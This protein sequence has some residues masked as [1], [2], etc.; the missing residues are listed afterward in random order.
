[1]ALTGIFPSSKNI[2]VP[3]TDL[4]L[5]RCFNC[6]LIQL[7]EIFDTSV[8]FGKH[9]G[10][11]SSVTNTM[12]QHLIE[13]RNLCISYFKST[14]SLSIL[15]IGSN[16]GYLLNSYKGLNIKNRVG[17][18]PSL[19]LHAKNYDKDIVK[20]TKFFS[21]NQVQKTIPNLQFDIVSSI[22]MFYDL[23]DPIK[24]ATDIKE[25]LSD[26]G[27]WIS[28]QTASFTLLENNCYDSIC[29][30]HVCYY[31]FRSLKTLAEKVG[32]KIIHIEKND[33][34]GGSFLVVFAKKSSK[35]VPSVSVDE[36]ANFE[37]SLNIN[38]NQLWGNYDKK[39]NESIFQLSSLI[40]SILLNKKKIFGYGAS[41]KGN[42]L[43][44][45]LNLDKKKLPYILER[46]P[47]KF[48]KFTP[49]TNIPIISEEKGKNMNPDYLLVLPWHFKQEIILREKN[50]LNNGGKLIFPLPKLEI[51]E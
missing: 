15:D 6:S 37:L 44:Q 35:R 34:N 40:N 3:K 22:A 33:I 27:V 50:Y 39:V 2:S 18:D 1:M 30:E 4:T 51:I 9:Y 19:K 25:I 8:F 48:G 46:D 28:E 24:F 16:D 5:I 14:E 49:G 31:S 13:V 36:Y 45:L 11:R 10:Y 43:L 41:T 20:I 12:K 23:N 42:I 32:L 38:D 47:N 29:H 21:K 17:I 7:K 26:E